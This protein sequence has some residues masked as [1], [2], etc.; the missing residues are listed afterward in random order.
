M[1]QL[2]Y[3]PELDGLRAIAV[4]LVILYHSKI[5]ILNKYIFA[6]GFIG[7][8]IFF[9]I[10]G[11]LITRIILSEMLNTG[12]F[13]VKR[14]YE[15]RARRILPAL[16][17]IL[18][19]S[20]PFASTRLL[21]TDFVDYGKSLFASIFSL[22]N[23]FF[24]YS[25]TAYGAAESQL[26][27]LL[28]TWSLGVEEQFYLIF[29][30]FLLLMFNFARKY[31]F[32]GILGF[33]LISFLISVLIERGD[34]SLAFYF[35]HTRFWEILLGSILAY[36]EFR[37]PSNKNNFTQ[38]LPL[39][40]LMLIFY[41]SF[42]FNTENPHPG[43]ITLIPLIGTALI[44]RYLHSGSVINN[45]LRIRPMTWIG[46][47][48]YSLYLFHFPMFAFARIDGNF[49]D[50]IDKTKIILAAIALSAICYYIIE[51]PLRYIKSSKRFVL[52][53]CLYGAVLVGVISY[54][55]YFKYNNYF[56]EKE[57]FEKQRYAY[58]ESQK[59][60]VSLPVFNKKYLIVGDS[61][62]VDALNIISSVAIIDYEYSTL[63]GCPPTNQDEVLGKNHPY[64]KECIAL[65]KERFSQNLKEYDGVVI[66]GRYSWFSPQQ[67]EPYLKYLY[68]AG[69]DNILILGDL[70]GIEGGMD[71]MINKYRKE[72]EVEKNIKICKIYSDKDFITVAER[73]GCHFIS[74]EKAIIEKKGEYKYFIDGVPIIYDYH[75]LTT[76]AS[77]QIGAE[78][79]K[80]I[81]EFL[82]K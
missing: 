36:L 41:S 17:S 1:I 9:V 60:D 67:L 37:C 56:F 79:K 39:A 21:F 18:L 71:N 74:S 50:N 70:F 78:N 66:A 25:V 64:R 44:V 3:R 61:M 10:S 72:S 68:E 46:K 23:I 2:K 6:G 47:I 33:F 5:V 49:T 26:K 80:E 81:L 43:F 54:V 77:K 58:Y 57:Y 22:S 52:I 40:G 4:I 27:P 53:I 7:V 14:F 30:L 29:P 38:L 69:V 73:W 35:P 28:H 63:G 11:Y 55:I 65:N 24:H 32:A 13:S 19:I 48:S 59:S 82:S 15:K 8:D 62:V 34:P 75:H 42:T 12:K 20:I 51:K 31:L 76:K 16:F 45:F